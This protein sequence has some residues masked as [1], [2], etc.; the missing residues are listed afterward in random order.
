VRARAALA[1]L[2]AA[3]L[4]GPATAG[5]HG[6][7]SVVQGSNGGYA[8]T[9]LAS[10][11][12]GGVDLTAYPVRRDLGEPDP[13]AR[14]ELAIDDGSSVRRVAAPHVGDGYEAI[15]AGSAQDAR[16]WQITAT[17]DGPAGHAVVRG[18]PPAQVGA[19]GPPTGL[20]AVSVVL[21]AALGGLVVLVR[22]RRMAQPA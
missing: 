12:G 1:L 10:A 8:V 2:L 5:A 21:L 20:I 14:V 9:V 3:A 15:V 18:T 4:A 19:G 7:A 13:A 17:V 16:T 11:S 6:G 22:R